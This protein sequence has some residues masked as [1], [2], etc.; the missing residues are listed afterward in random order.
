MPTLAAPPILTAL[1]RAG[2]QRHRLVEKRVGGMHYA[3]VG[4]VAVSHGWKLHVSSRA[5]RY[6][7]LISR[8]LDEAVVRA[9]PFKLAMDEKTVHLINDGQAGGTQIGKVITFYPESD[10]SA[11]ALGERLAHLLQ[12]WP[13][14]VIENELRLVPRAPVFARYGAFQ[15]RFQR[16]R[17][18]LQMDVI[19]SPSG[20]LVH[21]LRGVPLHEAFGVECPFEGAALASAPRVVGDRFVLVGLMV[22]TNHSKVFHAVDMASCDE[23]LVKLVRRHASTDQTGRDAVDRLRTEYELLI[24]LQ[25]PQLTRPRAFHVGDD[26]AAL[27]M[28]RFDAIDLYAWRPSARGASAQR[29]VAANVVSVLCALHERGVIVGD[30][31]PR[32][33]L[34]DEALDVYF[35]DFECAVR[36]S[37][38]NQASEFGAHGY[39]HPEVADGTPLAPRHDLYSLAAVLFFIASGIELSAVPQSDRLLR[40]VGLEL[41]R[42][43]WREVHQLL[44]G[45]AHGSTVEVLRHTRA[46]LLSSAVSDGGPR[47]HLEI[48]RAGILRPTLELQAEDL[49]EYL[50]RAAQAVQR[51]SVQDES[52]HPIWISR[53]P[54]TRDQHYSDLQL[55]DAGVALALLRV[56]LALSS[57]EIVEHAVDAA[58]GLWQRMSRSVSDSLPGLFVGDGGAALLFLSLHEVLGTPDWLERA[59]SVSRQLAGL[60]CPSPDLLHGK[61]GLGLLHLWAHE[62]TSDRRELDAAL[63]VASALER[64]A[65]D[66]G[67]SVGWVIPDGYGDLSGQTLHG[68]AHGTAGIVYFLNE[69]LRVHPAAPVGDLF[70]RALRSLLRARSHNPLIDAV[71]WPHRHG[72]EFRGGVWC[73]GS[74]GVA[75]SLARVYQ[76]TRDAEVREAA[77]DAARAALFQAQWLGTSQCHGLAGLIEVLLDLHR[78]TQDEQWCAAARQLGAHLLRYFTADTEAGPLVPSDR[79]D[80]FTA[81][82]MVGASGAVASLARLLDVERWGSLL[83]PPRDAFRPIHGR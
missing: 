35:V 50:G 56:G 14:P 77:E 78:A 67:S 8:L 4:S 27:A 62:R 15:R 51:L 30:I 59:V 58:D 34:V 54:L 33:I 42:E 9:V 68:M 18:G 29:T 45:A 36:Q 32:N 70:A 49:K 17:L 31:N 53:H 20:K 46:R 28:T 25:M 11:R 63:E 73:H 48:L 26:W 1:E 79:H 83:L 81:E 82:L 12:G 10:A 19:E 38:R 52:G 6:V 55:G 44:L 71:D 3:T 76:R 40:E 7:E 72:G 16:T 21:D 43:P 22:E 37:E 41:P 66:D 60:P 69:L 13:G 65:R 47:L 39:L 80:L 23:C 75:Q 74:A 2:F 64:S 5:E 24:E 61:A 57:V